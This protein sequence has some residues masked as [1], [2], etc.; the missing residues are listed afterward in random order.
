MLLKMKC[1]ISKKIFEDGETS[2]A[3]AT[4]MNTI[5]IGNPVPA[6]TNSIGSGDKFDCGKGKI[7]KKKG[8]K[9]II[10]LNKVNTIPVQK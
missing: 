4:T 3:Y 1:K 9:K 5:G 2:G 8:P 7:A 6:G 10:K